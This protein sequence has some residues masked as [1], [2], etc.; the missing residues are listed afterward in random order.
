[1][2]LLGRLE[3]GVQDPVLVVPIRENLLELGPDGRVFFI[4]EEVPP[5]AGAAIVPDHDVPGPED[6]VTVL[7]G[8][9]AVPT[10][11]PVV[12]PVI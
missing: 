5:L 1:M 11:G 9:V 2:N 7:V 10:G 3:E 12:K 8:A 4:G 6:V